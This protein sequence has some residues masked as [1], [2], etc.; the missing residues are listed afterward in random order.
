[1]IFFVPGHFKETISYLMMQPE[2][3]DVFFINKALMGKPPNYKFLVE[4]FT[5][6]ENSKLEKIKATYLNG[7]V[8]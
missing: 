8:F 5:T 3:L 7:T 2:V 6:R 4:L 1:M